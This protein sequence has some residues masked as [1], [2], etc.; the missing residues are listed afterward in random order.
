[1]DFEFRHLNYCPFNEV[2]CK[3]A[4]MDGS[5]DHYNYQ[6]GF[7]PLLDIETKESDDDCCYGDCEEDNSDCSDYNVNE[8]YLIDN[9][10]GTF[11]DTENSLVWFSHPDKLKTATWD[12]AKRSVKLLSSG[13]FGLSD[14]SN[15]SDWRLPTITELQS[16]A[17]HFYEY[18]EKEDLPFVTL[19][20]DDDDANTNFWTS[21]SDKELSYYAFS[22]DICSGNVYN[23]G[24]DTP[25][26][27]LPV[28]DMK[29]KTTRADETIIIAE[30]ILTT[31]KNTPDIPLG[32]CNG[33]CKGWDV[34]DINQLCDT[35]LIALSEASDLL[36]H[37]QNFEQLLDDIYCLSND[38]K[39]KTIHILKQMIDFETDDPPDNCTH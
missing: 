25:L 35:C 34:D 37:N 3:D 6:A 39:E 38:D 9:M 27:I 19:N 23:Y 12:S 13:S 29:P 18:S 33:K 8:I 7:C 32:A 10:N 24:K 5:C 1:M 30:R 14:K 17:K 31:I 2:I 15:K 20:E 22:V 26:Y 4:N 21:E 16:L 36:I 11:T 28:R